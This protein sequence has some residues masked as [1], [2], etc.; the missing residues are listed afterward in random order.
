MKDY[1]SV[2]ISL[3]T[4]SW[5]IGMAAMMFPAITPMVLLYNRLIKRSNSS[6]NDDDGNTVDKGL[7]SS[8]SSVFVER[9][10]D[11]DTK[12]A[13]RAKRSSLSL[14][15]SLSLL[16]IFISS[17]KII[18]FVGSYPLVWAITGIVLLLTWYIRVNYFF[19]HFE[20]GQQHHA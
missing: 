19:M 3:F 2:A 15:L 4:I 7:A 6:S 16:S 8:Q 18:F 12:A 20:T 9:G 10:D 1:N 17:V 5:T 13:K 14:S 11:D